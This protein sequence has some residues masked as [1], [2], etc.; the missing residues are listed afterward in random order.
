MKIFLCILLKEAKNVAH[1]LERAHVNSKCVL[2]SLGQTKPESNKYSNFWDILHIFSQASSECSLWL[3]YVVAGGRNCITLIIG[4]QKPFG[5]ANTARH[6]NHVEHVLELGI[7]DCEELCCILICFKIKVFEHLYLENVNQISIQSLIG[8]VSLKE[9]V[10]FVLM[11]KRFKETVK[12]DAF[13]YTKD[14]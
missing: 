8:K 4:Y 7:N 12:A 10:Y 2:A 3:C 9:N 11:E 13:C 6:K 14:I 5:S 1:H